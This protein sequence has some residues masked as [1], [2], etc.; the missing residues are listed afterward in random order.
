[1][2]RV[3]RSSVI[4]AAPAELFAYLADL[5]NLADWQS[6]V[7]SARRT[8][9]GPIGVGSTAHLVRQLMGQRIE[10]PL[11]ITQHDPPRRLAIESTVSGIGA[12]ALLELAPANDGAATSLTF[13]MEI[14]GSGMTAFMEPMVASAAAG[15]IQA[16]LER[17]ATRFLADG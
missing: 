17:L 5:D 14:R 15:D 1:M 10:A 8:S 6:G 9:D 13:T 12:T 7:T 3:Q 4:A 11:T 2:Q 16:S